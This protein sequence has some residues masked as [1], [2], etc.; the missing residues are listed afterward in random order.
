MFAEVG[1]AFG[2]FFIM[3]FLITLFDGITMIG[4]FVRQSADVQEYA[5]YVL[6]WLKIAALLIFAAIMVYFGI[7]MKVSVYTKVIEFVI[8]ALLAADGIASMVIKIKF[9]GKKKK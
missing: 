1:I 4:I 2:L 6:S 8:A 3:L 9:G 7:I 5:S